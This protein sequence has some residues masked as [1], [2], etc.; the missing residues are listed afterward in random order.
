MQ[1]GSNNEFDP[2][3]QTNPNLQTINEEEQKQQDQDDAQGG[4]ETGS[5]GTQGG[6]DTSSQANNSNAVPLTATNPSNSN[7]DDNSSS[8]SVGETEV[9][10]YREWFALQARNFRT[11]FWNF[12]RAPITSF[13]KLGNHLVTDARADLQNL[14]EDLE[15]TWD[16]NPE[17]YRSSALYITA[18]L[19]KIGYTPLVTLVSSVIATVKF[20]LGIGFMFLGGD[21]VNLVKRTLG[22]IKDVIVEG[23]KLLKNLAFKI[24]PKLW[25]LVCKI[26]NKL[27]TFASKVI[28]AIANGFKQFMTFVRFIGRNLDKAIRFIARNVDKAV[29]FLVRNV[30]KAIRFVVRNVGKAIGNV[31]HAAKHT[32]ATA[33]HLAWGATKFATLIAKG[34]ALTVAALV[35]ETGLL[36]VLN[37]VGVAVS[38]AEEGLAAAIGSLMDSVYASGVSFK[39]AIKSLAGYRTAADLPSISA[40]FARAPREAEGV[41]APIAS[42]S[43]DQDSPA[44]DA[45]YYRD[46][47]VRGVQYANSYVSGARD[48]ML[49][50]Y[51]GATTN[52][53]T[54]LRARVADF[55]LDSEAVQSAPARRPSNDML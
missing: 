55:D 21:W 15:E 26:G 32:F 20:G 4:E 8:S 39:A 25:E 41:D 31:L 51:N 46:R 54:P 3:G 17:D 38:V 30:G 29:R 53:N 36:R 10:T 50:L 6:Q 48:R 9:L 47:G 35:V 34:V 1:Q 2:V 13:S 43:E 16:Y 23:A 5:T 27:K 11:G 33:A 18:V 22:T 45:H 42:I 40:G 49:S 37:G 14:K 52:D 7:N 44:P 28:S 19:G 12:L 24:F